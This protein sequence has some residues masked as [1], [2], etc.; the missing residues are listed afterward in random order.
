[1]RA[2]S[3]RTAGA[4]L[5][6]L[7]VL[8]SISCRSRTAD[9]VPSPVPPRIITVAQQQG[10]L[11]VGADNTALQKAVDML[12][13]GDTL[14]IGSGVY[15]LDNSLVIPVSGVVVRGVPGETVLRKGP[16]VSSLVLDGGD[17]GESDLVVAEPE[18]FHPGMGV[19]MLDDRNQ[20]GYNVVVATVERIDA[21]T[22]R[23]SDRSVNDLDYIDGNTR[24]ENKFPLLCAYGQREITI[25]GIT[26]DGNKEENPLALD[27]CRGGAIYLFDCRS[28]TV[29]NCVARNYNGDGISF[30]ITDSISVIDCEACDNTGYGVH[31]GTGSS[32]SVIRNSRFHHNGQVGFFLCYRVRYGFF[33]DNLIEHNGR[34]GISVGHKDS[35][36]LFVNNTVR[37][38]GFCGVYFR[39]N[40]ERVGG[41]RNV[42]RNNKILDNGGLEEGYGVFVEA[43]N[44]DEVFED[45]LIG[46]TRSGGERTQQ[47]GVYLAAGTSSVKLGNNTMQGH[48]KVDHYRA[49]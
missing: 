48:L 22:L 10:A 35:D 13:P 9:T 23:L 19:A 7:L 1:M 20:W 21:D 49:E 14:E 29:R 24:V 34:Y 45:N 47:Y 27:G 36:N 8:A 15:R 43:T 26:A 18:K 32:H 44:K 30:Q 11:V 25:E 17:W 31:P 46:E 40:P 28:C 39:K 4:A 33:T 2:G 5:L 3:A 12:R 37:N 38:N 41:H 16:G 6:P 42:F